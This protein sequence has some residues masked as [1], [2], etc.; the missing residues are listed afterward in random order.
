M[1]KGLF[2]KNEKAALVAIDRKLEEI[3]QMAP[4]IRE[5]LQLRHVLDALGPHIATLDALGPHIAT[6]DALGPHIATLDALGSHIAVFDRTY[7][8][9]TNLDKFAHEIMSIEN[10][11]T[12]AHL[13]QQLKPIVDTYLN[14][15]HFVAENV[16]VDVETV[17]VLMTALQ[18]QINQL[19]KTIADANP[20]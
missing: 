12:F 6:L 1:L 2:R 7:L 3:L 10:V 11:A 14:Q 17:T 18:M 19:Q 9:L 8:T 13:V 20:Q 16:R 4:E 15:N 5:L